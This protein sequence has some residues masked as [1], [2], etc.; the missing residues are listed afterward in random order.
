MRQSWGLQREERKGRKREVKKRFK[1]NQKKKN[2]LQVRWNERETSQ[3]IANVN[4]EM[5]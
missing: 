4:R 5:L 2:F 1:G 3:K